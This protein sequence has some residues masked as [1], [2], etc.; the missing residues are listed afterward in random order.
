ME[1]GHHY[2]ITLVVSSLLLLVLSSYFLKKGNQSQRL[3]G[4]T[5]NVGVRNMN[6]QIIVFVTVSRHAIAHD[7]ISNMLADQSQF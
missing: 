4:T 5:C 3:L 7:N 2:W 6:M 1:K